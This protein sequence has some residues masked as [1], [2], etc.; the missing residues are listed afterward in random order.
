MAGFSGGQK[1]WQL[2][3]LMIGG[4]VQSLGQTQLSYSKTY[5]FNGKYADTD[6]YEGEWRLDSETE[7]LEVYNNQPTGLLYQKYTI[8][9]IS[10]TK[11]VITYMSNGENVT[12]TYTAVK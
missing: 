12:T 8:A 6:A 10:S 11:L 2:S 3:S 4:Q 1:T 7:I 5:F 9:E